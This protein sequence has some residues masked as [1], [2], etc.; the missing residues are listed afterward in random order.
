MARA[1]RV[2]RWVAC[3]ILAGQGVARTPE[4]MA[5]V[6]PVSYN[7]AAGFLGALRSVI[8]DMAD[9][10]ARGPAGVPR[11]PVPGLAE[12]LAALDVRAWEDQLAGEAQVVH[13][14]SEQREAL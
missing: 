9:E 7:L 8:A 5:S 13:Q 4:A 1:D 14:G 12:L 6:M 10:L 3:D 2:A 11:H